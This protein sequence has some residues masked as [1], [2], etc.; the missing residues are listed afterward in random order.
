[1]KIKDKV[2]GECEITHIY[3]AK[4]SAIDSYIVSADS[5]TLDRE[6]TDEEVEKLDERHRDIVEEYAYQN[7][8]LNHN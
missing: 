6:L 1:M 7:G 3:V 4:S 8:S 2:F 5:I